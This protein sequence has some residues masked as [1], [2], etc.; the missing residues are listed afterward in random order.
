MYKTIKTDGGSLAMW[1]NTLEKDGNE[2][3]QILPS[4]EYVHTLYLIVYKEKG[5]E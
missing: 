3:Y 1:L 2:I 5:N 4:F